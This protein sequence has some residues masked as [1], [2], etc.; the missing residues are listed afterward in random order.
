[1]GLP[2]SEL[3]TALAQIARGI[4][5]AK[6][7]LFDQDELTMNVDKV[8]VSVTLV[9]REGGLELEQITTTPARISE[10][11]DT[12]RQ[13]AGPSSSVTSESGNQIANDSSTETTDQTQQYGRETI[14]RT[15]HKD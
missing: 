7:A 4:A 8:D 12:Q 11:K 15:E 5:A 9:Y 13:V 1:M 2:I 6:T 10:S 3:S 14:N